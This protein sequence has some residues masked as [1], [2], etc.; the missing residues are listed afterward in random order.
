M[1]N[2]Y[3]DWGNQQSQKLAAQQKKAPT[4]NDQQMGGVAPGS[5]PM[6]KAAPNFYFKS[7]T[8]VPGKTSFALVG[9]KPASN[10]TMQDNRTLTKYSDKAGNS[11]YEDDDGNK[12]PIPKSTPDKRPSDSVGIVKTPFTKTMNIPV[13]HLKSALKSRPIKA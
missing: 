9:G 13:A 4:L 3:A 8:Q 5:V 2:P 10:N 7:Q 1:G 6:G 11:W 12:F